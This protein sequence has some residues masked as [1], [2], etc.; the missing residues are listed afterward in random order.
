MGVDTSGGAADV[1]E[2]EM[3]ADVWGAGAGDVGVGRMT[4]WLEELN[5]AGVVVVVVVVAMI[6]AG[7]GTVGVI[8]GS[9]RATYTKR[10]QYCYNS[11][12]T[13][14]SYFRESTFEG[15]NAA[16]TKRKTY[17]QAL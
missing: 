14:F 17:P 5:A 4:S 12:T 7:I 2:G 8:V 9:S 13:D 11:I 1:G 16:V 10:K 6:V 3:I 15:S